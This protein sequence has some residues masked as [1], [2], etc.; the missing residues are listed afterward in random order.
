VRPTSA[1]VSYQERPLDAVSAGRELSVDAVVYGSF[2]ELG[3]RVRVTVQLVSTESGEPL[4]GTKIDKSLDDVFALQDEVSRQIVQALEVRLTKHDEDRLHQAVHAASPAQREYMR[5]RVAALHES[6]E[7]LNEA[8]DAFQRAIEIDPAFAPAYAGLAH[9]FLNIAF[10]YLPESDY[11]DRA[12]L[13]CE[14]ALS[15]D[16][17]LSEARLVRARL[18]WTP[19]AGFNHEMAMREAGA[20]LAGQP[21]LGQGWTTMGLI[22]FHIGLTEEARMLCVRSLAIDPGDFFALT[23]V[24]YTHYLE[25]DWRRAVAA[26]AE[27]WR[28]APTSWAGYQLALSQLHLGQFAEAQQLADRVMRQFVGDVLLHPINALIAAHHGDPA[29]VRHHIEMTVRHEKGFGHYHHA[30]Y[31]VGCSLALIGAAD[32]A[33]DWLEQAAQNG[34]PCLV[35][36][37]QDPWLD[38]LRQLP[39]FA[40]LLTR[41]REESARLAAVY[42]E[43]MHDTGRLSS[44]ARS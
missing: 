20:A 38:S 22:A 9:A 1:I 43:V 27:V 16:P 32:E 19:K 2:Q 12:Q 7:R 14:K 13:M 11:Y 18:A 29:R 21:N 26:A 34:F 30:Q 10:T 37:E 8:I 33:L 31:D 44:A 4:W 6:L 15:I 40:A 17:H 42:R 39:R 3:G 35:L 28:R 24:A 25:G 41:L 5:G 36:F 23:H